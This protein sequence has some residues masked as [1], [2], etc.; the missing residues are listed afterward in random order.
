MVNYSKF[1]ND[2]TRWV[3]SDRNHPRYW[4]TSMIDLYDFPQGHDSPYTCHNGWL[5]S[6]TFPRHHNNPSLF[7]QFVPISEIRGPISGPTPNLPPPL[8][9]YYHQLHY[10]WHS[11]GE[12]HL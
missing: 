10:F 6:R 8:F 2:L 4:Y 1:K 5:N 12:P 9:R 11:P 3:D 7:P